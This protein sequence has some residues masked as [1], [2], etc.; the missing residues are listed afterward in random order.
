MLNRPS[1]NR[2]SACLRETNGLLIETFR[3]RGLAYH[4]RRLTDE[5]GAFVGGPLLN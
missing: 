2:S 1:W 5:D 3:V 4:G